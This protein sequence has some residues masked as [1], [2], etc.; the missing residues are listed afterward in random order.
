MCFLARHFTPSCSSD[1]ALKSAVWK[2]VC[3]RWLSDVSSGNCMNVKQGF[4]KKEFCLFSETRGK[5]SFRNCN[6]AVALTEP[7]TQIPSEALACRVESDHPAGGTVARVL[8]VHTT[9]GPFPHYFIF[10]ESRWY[11][12]CFG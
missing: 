12:R 3:S 11:Q 1:A 9:R 8:S 4:K 10:G 5:R 2:C 6:L 7:F